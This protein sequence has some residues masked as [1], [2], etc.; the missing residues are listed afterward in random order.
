MNNFFHEI[1]KYP[2]T[3]EGVFCEAL[4]AIQKAHFILKETDYIKNNNEKLENLL[5][6]CIVQKAKVLNEF[7]SFDMSRERPK[8]DLLTIS[9]SEPRIDIYI[10]ANDYFKDNGIT[11]ECKVIQD[12]TINNYINKN[13]LISFIES[14]YANNKLFA[15]MIAYN[16][17]KHTAEDVITKLNTYLLLKHP[18][19][20]V[21]E[22]ELGSF[23][24]NNI[25]LYQSKH[26]RNSV[27]NIDIIHLILDYRNFTI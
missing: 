6:R 13:G 23:C 17:S 8:D 14:K 20:T 27:N 1:T 22:I 10:T 26:N 9:G 19:T 25:S 5:T 7:Y 12:S 3:L 16:F 15:G 21:K 11:V 4:D 2:H 18:T 24:T